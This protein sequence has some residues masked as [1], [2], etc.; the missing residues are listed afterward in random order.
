M[1]KMVISKLNYAKLV[2]FSLRWYR[3]CYRKLS[4]DSLHSN[5]YASKITFISFMSCKKLIKH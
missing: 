2:K 5:E 3:D 4:H 1:N